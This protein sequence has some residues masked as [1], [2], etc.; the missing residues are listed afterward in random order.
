MHVLFQTSTD[1]LKHRAQRASLLN[2]TARGIDF[3]FQFVSLMIL[4]RLLTP[5]D[6]GVF[7]MVTP[8]LWVL[9]TMGDLGLASAVLQ[10]PDLNERQASAIFQVNALTG[11]ALAGLLLACSPLLGAFYGDA[12]V[13]E[14]AAILSLV[15]VVSGFTAVQQ[16]LLRRA[17]LF[18]VLLRAQIASSALS[19]TVAVAL[20][21]N[22]AG[23]WALVARAL[24]D[25]L[26]YASVAW[27]SAAWWPRHAEWGD[28][29]KALL[30][31]GRY[32]L[33]SSLIY[34]L[35]RQA[36]NVLIGWRYGSAE[37]GPYALAYRLFFLP[38]Q[39]ITWPLGHV[40]VPTLS[41]LRDDPERLKRWYLKLLRLVTLAAF[42]PFFSL[43]VCADDVIAVTAGPQW[44]AA[45]DILEIL[46][47]VGALQT[48]YSTCDWLLRAR[49]LADRSFWWTV[50]SSAACLIGYI[51]G[52]PW[53]ALGVASGLAVANLLFFLPG[54]LYATKGT[55]I[56]LI[57]AV[58]AM[59]PCFAVAFFAVAATWALRMEIASGWHPLARLLST[60]AVIAVIMACGWLLLYRPSGWRNLLTAGT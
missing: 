8:F 34:S 30:R 56:G 17:L 18:G 4:A 37:L 10:Q 16:A 36:D 32:Y 46:A 57:D 48:A 41:R 49:G 33:G 25:P 55:S 11:L 39:Q 51:I 35:A 14:I 52:L 23:Y 15:L 59:L 5:A 58:K 2:L 45:A 60:G 43:M 12:R 27:V 44:S 21:W 13:S 38:V 26:V 1:R 53:G 20:A 54:F 19:S 28:A 22:G 7:A 31:F 24:V 29:T 3:S 42:P 40:V 6:Y 47:P 50:V 9:I